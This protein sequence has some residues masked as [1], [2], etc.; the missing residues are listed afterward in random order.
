LDLRELFITKGLEIGIFYLRVATLKLKI[1]LHAG[2]ART[3]NYI[4][5]RYV[6]KSFQK[7]TEKTFLD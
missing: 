4:A 3:G 7:Y 6:T 2:M 5:T 1:S